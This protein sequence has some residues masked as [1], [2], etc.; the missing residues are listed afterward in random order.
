MTPNIPETTKKRV[1]IIGAGFGGLKIARDLADSEDFQIVLIDKNN[2]HQFQPLFYQVA[3]AGIEPS[4]I[5]FPLRLAFH[6][7]KDVHVRI[8]E[9]TELRTDSQEIITQLGAIRYDY[10]ILAIGADTNFFGQKNIQEKALP[11]K[12]VGE[13]LGLRNRLLENFE[14]ALVSDSD[15]VRQGLMTVV[16]VGGGPT[17]VEVSGTLAEMKRHVLPKDY[18][19]LDFDLM[20]VYIVESGGELLGPMSKNAQIKSKEY[21]EQLGV[22]V[23]LNTRVTDFDG[24]YAYLNNGEKIRTNNLVWAAGIKA[25][26]IEG[27]NPEVLARGG[28]IKVNRHN[29]VEGYQNIFAIGDVAF[30]TEEAFPNGHPQVAQPAIQQGKLLSQNLPK[31]LRGTPMEEFSYKDLGSMATVGRNLAVVD[32][33]FWRFQGFFAWLTWMFVHLMSIVGVK[34]RLLIFINWLWNYVTY[35]QSLRLII[36]QKSPKVDD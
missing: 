21:L 26:F 11:M 12:S 16:V 33:P 27:L 30:M 4:A 22:N 2:Y 13:A 24:K 25:N 3:T 20:K 14:N 7:Y 31:L 8:T 34:N 6:H 17:G 35:D 1:V 5:S 32:L 29:Q 36:K 19:E 18:P 28:R 23:F 15:D 9:V 10:L